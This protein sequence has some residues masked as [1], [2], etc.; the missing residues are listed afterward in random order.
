MIMKKL[1]LKIS[2]FVFLV[3]LAGCAELMQMA[4]QYALSES[5]VNRYLQGYLGKTTSINASGLANANLS[6]NNLNADIGR[7]DPDKVTLSGNAKFG[8]SSLLGSQTADLSLKMKARPVYDSAKG[9]VYLKDLEL[10]DYKLDSSLGSVGASALLPYLNKAL[11]FYFNEQP[12]YALNS[13]NPLEAAVL[14]LGSNIQVEQGQI[15]FPFAKQPAA[16]K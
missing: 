7:E 13:N 6:F 3:F 2:A 10:S 12:V 11:Q 8:I 16:V 9:A 15:V 1:S 4:S 14:K 5:M